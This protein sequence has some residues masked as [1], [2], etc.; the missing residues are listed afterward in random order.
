MFK[1]ITAEIAFVGAALIALF[2]LGLF[3]ICYYGL[4]PDPNENQDSL[5]T[6][7]LPSFTQPLVALAHP[8]VL[9]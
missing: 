5:D 1:W 6:A 2:V 7:S 9:V 8:K 3:I 4:Q